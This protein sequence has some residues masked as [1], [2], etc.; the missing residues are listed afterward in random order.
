M[1]KVDI[2]AVKKARQESVVDT[3]ENR[4]ERRERVRKLVLRYG[5][6][7]VSAASGWK[8]STISQYLRNSNP[9]IS[10][11]R[12]SEAERILNNI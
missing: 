7:A 11:V 6:D 3:R 9:M 2:N 4:I 5:Y 8:V 1:N 12:L 10:Q